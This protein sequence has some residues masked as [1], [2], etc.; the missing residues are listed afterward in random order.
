[1]RE[2]VYVVFDRDKKLLKVFVIWDT[3]TEEP[4]SVHR[5]EKGAHKRLAELQT[6]PLT[7][8]QYEYDEFDLE[9]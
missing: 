2:A 3:V 9:I 6:D 8:T 4:V 5:T 7:R 1:M